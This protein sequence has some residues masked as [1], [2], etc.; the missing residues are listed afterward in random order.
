MEEESNLISKKYTKLGWLDEPVT[1]AMAANA[2]QKVKGKGVG[3]NT[4]K[5]PLEADAF[6]S[7][8]LA[9]RGEI[10]EAFEKAFPAKRSP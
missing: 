6:R 7:L 10:T 9:R 1:V 4:A 8:S 2:P 3:G 5:I